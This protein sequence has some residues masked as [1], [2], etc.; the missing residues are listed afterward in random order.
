MKV[1]ARKETHAQQTVAEGLSFVRTWTL[2]Q[3]L[4]TVHR[5]GTAG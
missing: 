3:I 1:Q 5:R 2:A 4:F